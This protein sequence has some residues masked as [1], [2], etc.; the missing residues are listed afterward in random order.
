[1]ELFQAVSPERRGIEPRP[2]LQVLLCPPSHFPPPVGMPKYVF[3]LSFGVAGEVLVAAISLTYRHKGYHRALYNF[4]QSPSE[5]SAR[6]GQGRPT[7]IH[8]G[9]GDALCGRR[10]QPGSTARAAQ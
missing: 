9:V 5:Q 2:E 6:I 4:I 7:G 10:P 3:P 8:P 1:M